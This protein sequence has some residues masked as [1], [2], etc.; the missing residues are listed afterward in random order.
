MELLFSKMFKSE[1]L[2]FVTNR[3][4]HHWKE[5]KVLDDHRAY[6]ASGIKSRYSV[7][8][9][10]W[11]KIISEMRAFRIS[12]ISIREVKKFL[13]SDTDAIEEPRATIL[14]RLIT[15]TILNSNSQFLVITINGI[16][17]IVDRRE[18]ILMLTKGS[19]H[20]HFA[21]DL[22][23]L[24]WEVLLT[25]DFNKNIKSII[26]QYQNTNNE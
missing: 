1:H 8:D 12:N 6:A 17:K 11:I 18:Y 14:K 22:D 9:I 26:Q 5:I 23:H 25:L 7:F 3:Q 13:N 16:L 10:I 24:I 21:L 15:E 20:H 2:P 4:I 19:L